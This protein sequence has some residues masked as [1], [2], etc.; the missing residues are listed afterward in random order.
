MATDELTRVDYEHAPTRI[1]VG[2]VIMMIGCILFFVMALLDFGGFVFVMFNEEYR[3]MMHSSFQDAIELY[4]MPVLGLVLLFAGIGGVC[5]LTD[6]SRLKT[7]GTFAAIVFLLVFV[8]DTV[9]SIRSLIHDLVGRSKNPTSG[10][11]YT[12]SEAWTR[13][14]LDFLDIQLSGGIYLIGWAIIKDYVGDE[15]VEKPAK[16]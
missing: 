5:F 9:L 3:V 13:F 14:F 7:I 8:I 6:K 1:R 2:W 16:E 4:R 12:T 11:P 10:Q 15:R